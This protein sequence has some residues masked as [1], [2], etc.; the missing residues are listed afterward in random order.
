MLSF[1]HG[2]SPGHPRPRVSSETGLRVW[3]RVAANR[4]PSGQVRQRPPFAGLVAGSIPAFK[5]C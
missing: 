4:L 3:A 5:G 2:A 1:K